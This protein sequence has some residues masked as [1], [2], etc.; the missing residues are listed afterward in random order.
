MGKSTISM[1][2]FNR[3]VKLPEGKKKQATNWIH[4]GSSSWNVVDMAQAA[5]EEAG[6]ATRRA[7]EIVHMASSYTL[8]NAMVRQGKV[9]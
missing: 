8:C 4:G 2:I 6:Q 7:I 5:P 9:G 1:V 3:Y